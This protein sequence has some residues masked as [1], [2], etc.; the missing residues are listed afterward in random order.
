MAKPIIKVTKEKN[1]AILLTA[2][3]ELNAQ[4]AN[5][6]KTN[7]LQVLEGKGDVQIVLDE[8]TAFDVAALQ[9]T[10]LLKTEISNSGRKIVITLPQQQAL[11]TV[12]EKSSIHKIL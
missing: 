10:Y 6:L 2:M 4:Y 7:Y 8:V 1:N 3:G 5:E 12:L 9:L 11:K